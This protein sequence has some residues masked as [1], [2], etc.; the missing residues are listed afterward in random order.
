M[1]ERAEAVDAEVREAVIE[2]GGIPS[3]PPLDILP[4][5]QVERVVNP[6]G[7]DASEQLLS[8]EVPESSRL[9]SS[10]AGHIQG[11]LTRL[12]YVAAPG[13]RGPEQDVS[14]YSLPDHSTLLKILQIEILG[15]M[16]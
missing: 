13:T 6:I 10:V 12:S 15:K 14:A 16:S 4:A 8:R 2:Q 11:L 9:D 1:L 3:S 5:Q 7:T